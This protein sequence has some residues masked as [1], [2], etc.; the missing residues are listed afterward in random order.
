MSPIPREP[1]PFF[2]SLSLHLSPPGTSPRPCT[3][4][5][6]GTDSPWVPADIRA[7]SQCM[8]TPKGRPRGLVP[9]QATADGPLLRRPIQ[10]T[11]ITPEHDDNDTPFK[12][13]KK[14]GSLEPP[15]I[16][17]GCKNVLF[18]HEKGQ[19]SFQTHHS[20]HHGVS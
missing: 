8:R 13:K 20:S 2:P 3:Y 19:G 6:T 16:T 12:K 9:P 5:T 11:G 17:Q 14:H 7:E 10:A 18:L 15:N 1:W 4:N